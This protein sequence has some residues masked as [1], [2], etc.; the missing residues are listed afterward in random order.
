MTP[1]VRQFVETI[2]AVGLDRDPAIAS[3]VA[4][5]RTGRMS[6][7]EARARLIQFAGRIREA[8]VFPNLLDPPPD[9]GQF[10]ADG[11]PDVELGTLENGLRFGIHLRRRPR[12]ILYAASTGGGKTTGLRKM[13]IA[14]DGFRHER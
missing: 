7:W 6:E 10:Y 5:A 12:H 8:Q 2:V 9:E 11:R 1:F 13:V 3:L 14:V 4:R